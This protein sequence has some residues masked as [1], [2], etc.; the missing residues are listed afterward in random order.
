MTLVLDK[1]LVS[2][3]FYNCEHTAHGE[4]CFVLF[5]ILKVSHNQFSPSNS[6][7]QFY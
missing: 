4:K 1:F 7:I 3:L 5:F 6:T 2:V